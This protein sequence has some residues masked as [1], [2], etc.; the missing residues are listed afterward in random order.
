MSQPPPPK[1]KY[2]SNDSQD[3]TSRTRNISSVK[4]DDTN[5]CGL[6]SRPIYRLCR[7]R[8][9]EDQLLGG[10]ASRVCWGGAGDL[11]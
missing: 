7:L 10:K 1:K 2:C 11:L 3:G 4:E 8:P 5:H 9:A 6:H